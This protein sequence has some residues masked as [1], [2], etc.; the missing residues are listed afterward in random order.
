MSLIDYIPFGK[1]NAISRE[2]LSLKAGMGDRQ[3]RKEIERLR[4]KGHVILSSSHSGGY[5]QSD[6]ASEIGQY[7]A[8]N[9]SR[10]RKLYK[11][12]RKL[13][14]LHHRLTGQRTTTVH[15][16]IRRIR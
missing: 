12:N 8:E 7:I 5:W 14:E 15:E 10:I 13:I 16:H 11:T 4:E 1:Q 6:D 9:R 2:Q 3:M